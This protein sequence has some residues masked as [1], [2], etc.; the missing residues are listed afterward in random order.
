MCALEMSKDTV[1]VLVF[2]ECSQGQ[3]TQMLLRWSGD[4][5]LAQARDGAHRGSTRRSSKPWA[6]AAVLPLAALQPRVSHSASCS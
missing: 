3:E 4:A 1:S 6:T 2:S 5:R